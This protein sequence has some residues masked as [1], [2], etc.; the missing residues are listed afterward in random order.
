M[1]TSVCICVDHLYGRMCRL[2]CGVGVGKAFGFLYIA[3][4]MTKCKCLETTV[5]NQ[6]Y[7]REEI[8]IRLR[9]GNACYPVSSEKGVLPSAVGRLKV[10]NVQLCLSH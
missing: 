7:V 8:K 2:Y 6:F 3:D 9:F 10:E 4:Y 1:S 5:R